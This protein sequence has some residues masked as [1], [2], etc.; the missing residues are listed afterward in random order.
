M[1]TRDYV[2]RELSHIERM[3]ALLESDTDTGAAVM[4]VAMRVSHPS[5]WRERIEALLAIPGMPRHLTKLGNALLAKIDGMESR[6]APA[7]P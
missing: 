5:Y 2:E 6:P 3:V 1:L 4:P 7:K